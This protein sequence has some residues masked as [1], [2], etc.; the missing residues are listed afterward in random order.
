M[1]SRAWVPTEPVE[2]RIT[3][4]RV[5]G[6]VYGR[7]PER[8]LSVELELQR[9]VV[10]DRQTEQQRV[11]PV[12]HAAVA[13]QQCTEVL[14]AEVALQHRLA[15]IADERADRNEHAE[16]CALA[17]RPRAD[18]ADQRRADHD[19]REHA[20]DAAFDRLVGRHLGRDRRVTELRPDEEPDD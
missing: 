14:E 1:T 5:T 13:G 19:R 8:R 16:Y 4:P 2:P 6:S 10:R 12:E 18:L 17:R 15:Q 3:T 7:E 9:E 20:G 11:E